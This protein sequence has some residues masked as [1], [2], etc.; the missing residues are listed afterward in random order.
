[1]DKLPNASIENIL[2]G[3]GFETEIISL[4]ILDSK[5]IRKSDWQFNWIKELG[6]SS[7]QVYKLTTINEP[8]II[9]GLLSIEDK[10]D[11]IFVHLIESAN[12]NKG[13]GKVYSG[14]SENLV[15]FTGRIAFEK[16]YDGFIAFDEK[17]ALL[18]D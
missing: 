17:A 7:K 13:N 3:E 18:W 1:M 11:H 8:T 15:A 2:T 9:Q 10:N 4:L 14:V 16:G 5:Q 12:F 6:D